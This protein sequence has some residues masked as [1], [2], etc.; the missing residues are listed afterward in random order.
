MMVELT[1]SKAGPQRP[2]P[3]PPFH[4]WQMPDGSPWTAFHRVRAGIILRFP[5][6]ADYHVASDG[7]R[8]TCKPVPGVSAATIEHLFLNQV[9]PLALSRLGKCVFHA[10]AVEVDGAAIAFLAES[11]RGK[12]TL[13]AS[14]ASN[15]WRFLTDDG[16]QI[17]RSGS[18]YEVV[19]SH[20][21]LRL[22]QES[23]QA[24]LKPE[25][26]Q[27]Q[28]PEYNSKVRFLASSELLFCSEPR[29][30]RAA[31]ML[32]T[33]AADGLKIEP[34]PPA[35]SLI[36]WTRFA[37]ILDIEDRGMIAE[38]FRE[39]AE[40]A[41]RVQTFR[42]DYPRRFED[43]ARVRAAIVAHARQLGATR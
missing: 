28:G 24:L 5:D 22:W 19:P 7:H 26:P 17:E 8:V 40:L 27:L 43:L 25:A 2:F 13:A 3:Q 16:L 38:Q 36:E 11:G 20:P 34:I 6:L 29:P 23:Q 4:V 12:S 41:N 30:L 31:Y 14:F 15:G 21:S 35:D 37:F 39:T 32:G 33:G 18:E 42:L 10:S 1:T 9:Q